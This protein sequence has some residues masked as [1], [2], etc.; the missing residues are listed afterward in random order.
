M[1]Q[2]TCLVATMALLFAGFAPV[3]G[4][5]RLQR[6][7][8]PSAAQLD[9]YGLKL[10]WWNQAALDP[11]ADRV[12]HLVMDEDVVFIQS[13]S[14]SLT[15]FDGTTGKQLWAQQLGRSDHPSFSP[16]T[17]S[18]MV[19]VSVGANLF[20]LDKRTGEQRWSLRVG[21]YPSTSPAMDDKHVYFGALDGTV[22]A[23]NLAMS[24][25]IRRDGYNDDWSTMA[26]DWRFKAG[27]R[28]TTDPIV[29]DTNV[30]V[31]SRAGSIYAITTNE[32]K[33]KLAFQ[34]EPDYPTHAPMAYSGGLL[35][36]ATEGYKIYCV[37]TKNE[38][39]GIVWEFTSGVPIHH[40]PF[41]IG[42]QLYLLPDDGSLYC[43]D[44]LTGNRNWVRP[45]ISEFL[46]ASILHVYAS[47]SFGNI[48]ILSRENGG[49]VGV[50]PLRSF[51]TR[52]E[53][54]RTDRLI[55]ATET[56]RLLCIYE[57]GSEYPLYHKYP[58]RKPILPQFAPEAPSEE[59][60]AGDAAE[61]EPK[62]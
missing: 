22:Y 29:T 41:V 30:I 33:G 32:E 17:N 36:V 38:K 7:P 14:G 8:L 47:D 1:R 3:F 12:Q 59:Q 37:N 60:P 61:T 11:T 25:Q 15:A 56:G 57:K 45:R 53:N 5:N 20:A 39:G 58:E 2:F 48:V 18:E 42:N 6:D 16:V 52:L 27:S 9:R 40:Q 35:Y 51:N 54:D 26:I 28:I 4:Q 46:A 24:R 23:Y 62:A 34:F 49:E 13:R 44:K 10:A 21:S 55:V 31:G 43:L 50:L 19:L